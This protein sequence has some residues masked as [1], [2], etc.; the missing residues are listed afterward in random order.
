LI[1]IRRALLSAY[2]KQGL[3]RL[4]AALTGC[5]AEI[6]SSGGTQRWLAERGFPVVAL[7]EW[8]QLP[9]L[10]GGRVKTLHPRI[11]G[12]ILFRRDDPQDKAELASF[13]IEPIDLVAVNLYPFEEQVRKD[14]SAL[15]AAIEMIDV[16][17][18]TMLRAAAKN[19]RWVAVICD[20]ED[21]LRVAEQLE[22]NQGKLDEDLLRELAAKVFR[23]T[24]RYDAMIASYL[25]SEGAPA[26]PDS[27]AAGEPLLWPLRYGENP[28]QRGA[29]YSTP[30]G[31]PGGLARL[32]GKE[33][34]FNNL[35]D[36][37]GAA[38]LVRDLG[39]EPAAVVIKHAT[40]CGAANGGT[41]VEA[42]RRARDGDA[43]S[44]F[45]GIVG[46]NRVVDRETAAE[47]ASTFLELVVAPAFDAEARSLLAAKK[48]LI[49]MEGPSLLEWRRSPV[50]PPFAYRGLGDGI[51]VQDPVPEALG[52][53]GWEVVTKRA[54]TLA[55]ERALAFAWKIVRAVRSNGIVLA[56]EGRTLG[57]GGG[58]TS[59]IDAL[60]VAIHKAQ[61]EGHDLAGAVMASDAFFPFPD[62]VEV[63][64]GTGVTAIIQPG[65]SKRDADS[66][67]A[68]DAAGIAMVVNH[69][70]C[71]RHG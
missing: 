48:N 25:Q 54:P 11:H 49:L 22:A 42:Y 39:P 13:G 70:R 19:H 40:P 27:F 71:F 60:W 38:L 30:H 17:G 44:A 58:Q 14:P 8:A 47:I 45:G 69:A 2:E 18:P 41:L 12:G 51:L 59:R 68:A 1:T 24:A 61:R 28:S 52:E 20:P 26:M 65:G 6:L 55:E 67:A 46:L 16:G 66:V 4:A 7:E 5:G 32:Q 53:S 10:F 36:L 31:F 15:E 23:V 34:S 56:Q 63:A 50:A 35:Q 3:D 37:E 33:I 62:C 57:I 29:F 64:A 21:Y 43:L 9:S